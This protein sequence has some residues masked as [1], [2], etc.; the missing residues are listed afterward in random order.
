M[1]TYEYQ[2]DKCGHRFEKRQGFDDPPSKGCPECRGAVQRV[3]SG[4]LGIR[5]KGPGFASGG[6]GSAECPSGT[7][8]MRPQCERPCCEGQ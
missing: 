6:S 7:C 2:C 4:G 5:F 1:P 3:I 8:P